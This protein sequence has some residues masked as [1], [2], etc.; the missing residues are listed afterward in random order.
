[1]GIIWGGVHKLENS[2]L[3]VYASGMTVA[4]IKEQISKLTPEEFS[5]V[6][7]FVT[8]IEDDA[9][10]KQMDADIRAGKFAKFDREIEKAAATGEL[11]PCPGSAK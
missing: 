1:L 7:L 9:W 11:L 6:A 5:E 3:R 10:D 4:E 2:G 8:Q